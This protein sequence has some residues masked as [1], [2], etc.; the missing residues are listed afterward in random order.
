MNVVLVYSKKPCP[1]C[2]QAKT[3]LTKKGFNYT[4]LDVTRPD[5]LDQLRDL[6][7]GVKTVPQIFIDGNH[8][9]GYTELVEYFK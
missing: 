8:I 2:E 9:G 5:V 3:L 4:E 6:V 7:P 1:Y